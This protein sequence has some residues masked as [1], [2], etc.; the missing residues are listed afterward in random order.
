MCCYNVI[1]VLGDNMKSQEIFK[2]G[3]NWQVVIP[4]EVREKL[5]L[6]KGDYV[7]FSIDGAKV[8]MRKVIF[9]EVE[10]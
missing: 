10:A 2:V 6:H 8:V 7:S 1:I 5:S 4:P 9:Q 3:V